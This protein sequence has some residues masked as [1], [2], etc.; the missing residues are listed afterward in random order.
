M[1]YGSS[2][3]ALVQI[4]AEAPLGVVNFTS[5][6]GRP[7]RVLVERSA[8]GVLEANG[9]E[10]F[11][12]GIALSLPVIVEVDGVEREVLEAEQVGLGVYR[13]RFATGFADARGK[14]VIV[15][16]GGRSSQRNADF[17]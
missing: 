11:V 2:A 13:L 3:L 16:Q 7:F 1:I 14:R 17:N 4:P 8:P 6:G 5:G 9:A 10:V 15:R 12:T